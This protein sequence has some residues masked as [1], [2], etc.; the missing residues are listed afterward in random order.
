H[1][2]DVEYPAEAAD[3]LV[4]VDPAAGGAVA[5]DG[6][7]L[8]GPQPGLRLRP[9]GEG[10]AVEHG[11]E[12]RVAERVGRGPDVCGSVHGWYGD[13][14][15]QDCAGGQHPE[16]TTRHATH[17]SIDTY[18]RL[19]PFPGHGFVSTAVVSRSTTWSRSP[20]SD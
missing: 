8:D 4:E 13:S 12:V 10:L 16:E 20:P 18:R 15:R 14:G 2:P 5:V 6:S 17:G 9:A 19:R 3:L 11:D 7:V 1:L